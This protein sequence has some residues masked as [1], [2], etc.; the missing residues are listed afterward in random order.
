[1][2]KLGLIGGMSWVSTRTYFEQ[3]NRLVQRRTTTRTTAPLLIESLDFASLH[4][5]KDDADWDAATQHLVGSAKR[6]E[7]AGAEGLV[8]CANSMHKDFAAISDAVDIP[9]LHAG[10]CIGAK[11]AEAGKTNVALIGRRNVMTESFF[12]QRIVAHGVDLMSPDMGNVDLIDRIIYEE[13]MAG[14]ASRDAERLFKTII[15]Q[16]QQRGATAIIL[17][18]TELELVVDINANVLPIFDSASIHCEAAVDWI[19]GEN[20]RGD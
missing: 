4:A 10:D 14:K 20:H 1:M 7:Q 17:A 12:R 3:I 2:R 9:I 5:L 6:M 11:V 15:T 16:K 13:L 18:C 19:F 8:I